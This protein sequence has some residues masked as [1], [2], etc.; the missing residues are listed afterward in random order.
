MCP[1]GIKVMAKFKILTW[2][3]TD[4]GLWW[5]QNCL[6]WVSY[7]KWDISYN[8]ISTSPMALFI[9]GMQNAP[10]SPPP[11]NGPP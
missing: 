9:S 10:S 5:T 2:V 11:N 6:L 3:R 4:R 1:I 7:L 8:L